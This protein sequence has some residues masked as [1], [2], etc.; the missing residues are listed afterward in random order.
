MTAG[1]E[2]RL[3]GPRD[4]DVLVPLVRQYRAFDGLPF[5]ADEVRGALDALVGDAALGQVWL[6]CAG[7]TPV[8][9]AALCYGFS[10]EYGGRDAFLDELFL[11]APYRGQGWGRSALRCI[12]SALRAAG[13]RAVHLQVAEGNAAALHLYLSFGFEA[14]PRHLLSRRIT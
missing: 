8:G 6:I 14:S 3:A 1:P 13:V 9:Y 5:S 11:E 4:V 10:L 7:A 12:E 2:F